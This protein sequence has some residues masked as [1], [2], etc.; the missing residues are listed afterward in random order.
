MSIFQELKSRFSAALSSV[1]DTPDQYLDMIR[2]SQDPKFGDFQA[3]FAMPLAKKAG[4]NPREVAQQICDVGRV[5]FLRRT[6]NR[7]PRF[8]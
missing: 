3:N 1:T 7:R 4:K 8:H 6:R 2:A 5:R